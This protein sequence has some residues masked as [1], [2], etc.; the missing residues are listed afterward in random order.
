MNA[1][2]ITHPSPSTRLRKSKNGRGSSTIE[3]LERRQL[4]S[5]AIDGLGATTGITANATDLGGIQLHSTRTVKG[6]VGVTNTD[7]VYE[8]EVGASINLGLTLTKLAQQDKVHLLYADGTAVN[9][10]WQSSSATLKIS[11]R[12]DPGTYFVDVQNGFVAPNVMT[13]DTTKPKVQKIKKYHIKATDGFTLMVKGLK[14]DN[15]IPPMETV[16]PTT[17][18]AAFSAKGAASAEPTIS[19]ALAQQSGFDHFQ[20]F[21]TGYQ[22]WGPTALRRTMSFSRR[23]AIVITCRSSPASRGMIRD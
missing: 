12:L 18:S 23:W 15:T 6:T 7:T 11:Q 10:G 16:A 13:A 4:L 20:A 17:F 8:I 3:N 14:P 22:L 5:A 2:N 21:S 9:T 19:A 1:F